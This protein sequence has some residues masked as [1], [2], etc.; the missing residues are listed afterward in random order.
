M[1]TAGLVGVVNEIRAVSESMAPM[2]SSRYCGLNAICMS[3]PSKLTLDRLARLCL[4]TGPGLE[5]DLARGEASRTGVFR[6]ATSATRLTAS[7]NGAAGSS[8]TAENSLGSSVWYR[9]YSPD[10]S[11][12]VV[13]RPPPSKPMMPSLPRLSPGAPARRR[14]RRRCHRP[15]GV[16]EHAGGDEHG[17]VQ[18][19]RHGRPAQLADGEP[20]A[21]GGDQGQRVLGDLDPDPG[22]R[23]QRV[24]PARGD[25]DLAD[26][27]GERVGA[28]GSPVVSGMSGSVG[29]SSTGSSIRV[30]VALPQ[31]RVVLVPSV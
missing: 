8:A 19:G 20:V 3:S 25:S 4:V 10:S 13:L 14:P 1:I 28:D 21:V 27:R 7:A 31:R 6:S 18:P 24:V 29:Y 15:G 5:H 22:Q 11:R 30:K 16:G 9:G 26:R 12:V 17:G 23:G 2:P